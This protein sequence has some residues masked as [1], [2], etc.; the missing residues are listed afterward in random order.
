LSIE[1]LLFS[2]A[3]MMPAGNA[4]D[5]GAAPKGKNTHSALL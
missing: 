3:A 2:V 4:D 1:H 5:R